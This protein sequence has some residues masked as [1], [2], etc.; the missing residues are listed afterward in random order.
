MFMASKSW[1]K[2]SILKLTRS[3]STPT[4]RN[5]FFHAIETSTYTFLLSFCW[6]PVSKQS[7]G[8]FVGSQTKT[9]HSWT[10]CCFAAVEGI[11]FS[12]SLCSIFWL[13]KRWSHARIELLQ[14]AYFTRRRPP[15]RLCLSPLQPLL[16]KRP[17]KQVIENMITEAVWNWRRTSWPDSLPCPLLGINA[18][19]MEQY[20]IRRRPSWS[21]WAIKNTTTPQTHSI[22]FF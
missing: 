22:V 1:W 20:R 3:W 2:I 21:L 8:L 6:D 7:N 12:G 4:S 15:F 10:S 19:L 18:K 13:K 16:R 17:S 5:T 9:R 14:R 11:F